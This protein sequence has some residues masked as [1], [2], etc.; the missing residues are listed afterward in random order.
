MD[1]SHF[2]RIRGTIYPCLSLV[3]SCF[4]D[5]ELVL[6]CLAFRS[7]F[8]YVYYLMFVVLTICYILCHQ[9]SGDDRAHFLHNQTTANFESLSEG[10]VS[11]FKDIFI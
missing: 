8:A 7:D 1:L 9:V 2:G 10:Q 11:L 4:F 5:I 6:I 3:L